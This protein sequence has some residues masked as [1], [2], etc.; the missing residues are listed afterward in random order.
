MFIPDP[1]FY[2]SRISDPGSKN[3]NKRDR[4]KKLDVKPFYAAT[5]FN[6]ILNYFSFEVLKKKIWANFQRIIELFTKKI[7]K[8]LFKIW[9]WDPGSG[10]NPF[11]IQGSKRHRI[12]DPGSATLAIGI[13]FGSCALLCLTSTS[14]AWIWSWGQI[15]SPWLEDIVD[16]CMVFVV[17]ARQAT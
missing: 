10:K 1:D 7:V 9:P 11:R 14:H 15:L 2:P 3:S 4:W 6:K 16:S 12:P 13:W 17:P 5:K 8:K